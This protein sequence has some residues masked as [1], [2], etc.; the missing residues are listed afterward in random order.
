MSSK[1]FK[2]SKNKCRYSLSLD[3]RVRQQGR[4]IQVQTN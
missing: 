4:N 2:P 3:N 1:Q